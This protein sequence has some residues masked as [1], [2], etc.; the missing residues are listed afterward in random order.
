MTHPEDETIALASDAH[1]PS[2][3]RAFVSRHSDHLPAQLI[4]DAELLVTE[5]VTNAVKHGRPQIS[6]RVLVDPPRLGVLVRDGSDAVPSTDI[7]PPDQT[8]DSGR[9]LLIVDRASSAWGVITDESEAGKT[10]WFEL[11]ADTYEPGPA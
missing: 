8:A 9:G 7:G 6:L 5:L 11:T 3:A 4:S 10:V 1:A 2:L